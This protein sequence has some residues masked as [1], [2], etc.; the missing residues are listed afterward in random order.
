MP[1]KKIQVWVIGAI[2]RT[3]FD[4]R[5]FT[6]LERDSETIDKIMFENVKV[7]SRVITDMWAGY[8]NL[9]ANGYQHTAI[10][11]GHGM[12]S[13]EATTSEIESL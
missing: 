11:K 5:I 7:G 8:S 9:N 12:G 1:K 6:V 10:N 4:A 3:T 2:E 13:G